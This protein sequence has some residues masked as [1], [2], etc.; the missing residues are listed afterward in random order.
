MKVIWAM[1][2]AV[3]GTGVARA[4]AVFDFTINGQFGETEAFSTVG[5]F[6]ATDLGSTTGGGYTYES[7]LV[8]G[9]SGMTGGV[10][11]T[12][13]LPTY[14]FP[15]G[16]DNMLYVIGPY[17]EPGGQVDPPYTGVGFGKSVG[18]ALADGA[19]LAVQS[20]SSGYELY[21]YNTPLQD[22]QIQFMISLPEATAATPEPGTMGLVGTGVLGLVGMVRRRLR[23]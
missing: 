4:E 13:A 18:F 10:A 9:A 22:Q 21:T 2:L 7:Y 19:E 17:T 11:I 6:Y 8:T 5:T 14:T 20:G 12:G 1:V 3:L 23:G 16:N 15:F